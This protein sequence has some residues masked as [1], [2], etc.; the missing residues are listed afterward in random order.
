M[1]SAL[2][3]RCLVPTDPLRPIVSQTSLLFWI[4]SIGVSVPCFDLQFC[5]TGTPFGLYCSRPRRVSGA[6]FTVAQ[7]PQKVVCL[8]FSASRYWIQMSTFDH[9]PDRNENNISL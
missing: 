9:Y 7:E 3:S 6:E 8:L 1:L 4:V 5:P 2:P